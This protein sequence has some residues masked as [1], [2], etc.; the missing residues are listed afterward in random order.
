MPVSGV[1]GISELERLTDWLR[2]LGPRARGAGMAAVAAAVEQVAKREY[3]SSKG[4]RGQ[5]PRRKADGAVPLQRPAQA[6]EWAG[7]RGAIRASGEPVL[8]HH[9][10]RRHVFP[11]NGQLPA[12]WLRAAEDA[13]RRVLMKRAPT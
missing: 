12:S 9:R 5:W 2:S 3:A 10:K 8:E 6:T 11:P 13:L 7:K 4:P 1:S